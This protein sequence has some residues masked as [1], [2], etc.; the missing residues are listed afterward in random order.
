MAEES[1]PLLAIDRQSEYFKSW[2]HCFDAIVIIAGFIIDV[3]LKG[4]VE[5]AG[6]IVVVLR[7]WRVF[8]IVEELSAEAS[9][10]MATL[11]EQLNRLEKENSDLSTEIKALKARAF[12]SV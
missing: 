10:Q 4:I 1:Q 9:E 2:F 7:L 11:V 12:G 5:E 6:S 8:K 3:C